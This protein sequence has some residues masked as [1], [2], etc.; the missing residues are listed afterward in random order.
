MNTGAPSRRELRL[1]GAGFGV[2]FGVLAAVALLRHGAAAPY[3]AAASAAAL[4]FAALA[5]TLLLPLVLAARAVGRPL[6][7]L[8]TR[9]GLALVFYAVV[10]PIA[11]LGRLFGASFSDSSFSR[12]R[13]S[14]WVRKEERARTA[15]DYEKQY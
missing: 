1:A 7:W 4:A 2:A 8:A 10:T 13:E 12:R 5:P 15:G 11:V 14:Y 6:V 3:L 9:A